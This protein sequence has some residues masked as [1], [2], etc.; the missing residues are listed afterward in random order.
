[1]HHFFT[2]SPEFFDDLYRRLLDPGDMV[3]RRL[4]PVRSDEG[5]DFWILWGE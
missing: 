4:Y 2:D 3:G 1:L 5:A